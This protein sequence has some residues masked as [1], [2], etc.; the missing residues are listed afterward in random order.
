VRLPVRYFD[1]TQ[2]R[3]ADLARHERRRRDPESRRH[4]HRAARRR[5]VTAVLGI[6]VL[7]WLNWQLTLAILG[8]LALFASAMAPGP[9]R[10]LRPIFR[11]RGKIQAEITGRLNQTL[12]G[13]R[14]VKAYTA[15]PQEERVFGGGVDKLFDNI[16]AR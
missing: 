1:S 7:F 13:V 12:G 9:S 5:L 2:D 11:E 14:V 4:R 3:R 10:C 6:G 16:R 15:E 8:V